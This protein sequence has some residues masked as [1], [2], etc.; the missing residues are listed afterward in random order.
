VGWKLT[1]WKAN[2]RDKLTFK[3]IERLAEPGRY[4]DGGNL[5]LQVRGADNKSWLLRY[6]LHGRARQMGLGA[7]PDVGLA[8]ARERARLE[9]LRLSEGLDP[10]EE[11]GRQRAEQRRAQASTMLFRDAAKAVI[12]DRGGL[13]AESQRQWQASVD[14]CDPV[15][16][17]I[18]TAMIDTA[19]VMKVI[20]PM[21]K[22]TQVTAE[23]TRQRIEA[24]LD[25]ATARGDG[26]K[27]LNPARWKGHLQHLL[28]DTATVQHHAAM[29]YG[30]V[31]TFMAQLRQREG[32]GFRALEFLVLTGLRSNEVLGA[33]WDEI[34]GGNLTVPPERMKARKAH[35]V[36]LSPAVTKLL[37]ALP[38]GS[39]FV[40]A[41]PRTGKQMERHG[42]A[43]ALKATGARATVH[44][45]RSAFADWARECTAYPA[46]V[47][48]QA[49]A[50]SLPGKVKKA[51]LRG[52]LLE[53]RRRLMTA[54]ADYCS[55][56]PAT[57][58]VLRL[59]K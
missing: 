20:E 47:I 11:R 31:S 27:D 14:A 15:L 6:T 51:Y 40:F 4:A 43:D 13:S 38:R 29:P 49:L 19:L 44:G 8:D 3:R 48:E 53:K 56:T 34:S 5:W 32:V 9:R 21:W 25:S 26:R 16:G 7:F 45:F 28:K 41:A 18:P 39:E 58:S 23:R 22:R 30:E 10:L 2:M 57:A 50:H 46:E 36:P 33:R 52:D 24:V 17:S 35:T 12:A 54:W 1:K 59:H 37:D 55:K 42:A